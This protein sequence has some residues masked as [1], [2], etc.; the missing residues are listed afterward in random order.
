MQLSLGS[1]SKITFDLVK[2]IPIFKF[3]GFDDPGLVGLVPMEDGMVRCLTCGKSLAS[4]PSARRHY[5]LVHANN[6]DDRIS[7]QMCH[8]TFA[9]ESY[10]DDHMRRV[11][12]I[13]KKML[14]NRV[15][16]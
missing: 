10:V 9:A 15:L 5:S 6:K 1:C 11:H 8:R 12:G 3:V 14:K 4:M 16:P 2:E 7:C 13:S